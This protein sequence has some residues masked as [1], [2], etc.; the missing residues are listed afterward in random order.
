MAQ[1]EAWLHQQRMAR[2]SRMLV[3]EYAQLKRARLD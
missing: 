2:L 1:H 3:V